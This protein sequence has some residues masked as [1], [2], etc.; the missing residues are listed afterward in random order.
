MARLGNLEPTSTNDATWKR[1]AAERINALL[2][3]MEAMEKRVAA[4]EARP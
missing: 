2:Q 3:A 4:L 1:K